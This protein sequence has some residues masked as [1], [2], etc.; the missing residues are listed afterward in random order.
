M[1]ELKHGLAL[2]LVISLEFVMLGIGTSAKFRFG[3]HGTSNNNTH[4]V[5][6]M[7]E[8]TKLFLDMG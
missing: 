4:G 3:N 7:M 5:E 8:L 6:L 2:L 1:L